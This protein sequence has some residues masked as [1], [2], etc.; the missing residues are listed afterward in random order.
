MRPFLRRSMPS[1]SI[2]GISTFSPIAIITIEQGISSILSVG[3]GVGR[4]VGSIGP[5]FIR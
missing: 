4:P 1:A 2:P 3:T 5:A